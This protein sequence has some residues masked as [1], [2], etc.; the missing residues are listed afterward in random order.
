MYI[1]K[2]NDLVSFSLSCVTL[3]VLKTVPNMTKTGNPLLGESLFVPWKE[4]IS[5]GVDIRLPFE[6]KVFVDQVKL[7]FSQGM[8]LSAVSL[9]S[10]EKTQLLHRYAA[11]TGGVITKEEITLDANYETDLLT[12][13]FEGDFSGV[14][15]ENLEIF[16]SYGEDVLYPTPVDARI[17]QTRVPVTAFRGCWGDCPEGIRAAEILP[18]PDSRYSLHAAIPVRSCASDRPQLRQC[19]IH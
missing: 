19:R 6:K 3:S 12:L 17:T 5:S 1:G 11:E 13:V 4:K 8:K 2:L 16:G 18:A 9:Y 7:T 15:L 10:G 14:G